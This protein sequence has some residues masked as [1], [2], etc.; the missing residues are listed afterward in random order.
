[1]CGRLPWKLWLFAALLSGCLPAPGCPFPIRFSSSAVD[2]DDSD[3]SDDSN[4]YSCGGSSR[5]IR[6][7][8]INDDWFGGD[9]DDDAWGPSS[10]T[11]SVRIELY[12]QPLPPLPDGDD[13]DDDSASS[14][15]DDLVDDPDE[16]H[17]PG[18][19]P[20]DDDSATGEEDSATGDDDSAT[21][22]DDSATGDGDSATGD[23][24]SAARDDEPAT[25]DDDSAT[26]DDDS[27]PGDDDSATGDDDSAPGDDDSAP[28]DD[29]SVGDDDSW[30]DEPDWNHE[31]P[32]LV[33]RVTDV[34]ARVVIAYEDLDLAGGEVSHCSQ[35]IELGGLLRVGSEAPPGCLWC[36]TFVQLDPESATVVSDGPAPRCDVADLQALG[37]DASLP[38]LTP[39]QWG[40]SGELLAWRVLDLRALVEA[41]VDSWHGADLQE[42]MSAG[43]AGYDGHAALLDPPPGSWLLSH[44]SL[45]PPGAAWTWTELGLLRSSASTQA[46]YLELAGDYTLE[47]PVPLDLR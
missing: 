15:F 29:D 14:P 37:L 46:P 20:G 17:E 45:T 5:S 8:Y 19:P 32:P 30:G 33:A 36:S 12:V 41:H 23:G 4:T 1:M 47:L 3:D 34:T 7:G 18:D 28:G 13:D 27:A 24:D 26:G 11:A 35:T 16:D 21:G 10:T 40:G 2:S 43:W 6:S 39:P 38:L 42:V 9:D 44:S 31:L 25:G 22:D